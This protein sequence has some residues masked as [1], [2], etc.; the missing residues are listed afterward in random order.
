MHRSKGAVSADAADHIDPTDKTGYN[1]GRLAATVLLVRDGSDGLEVWAQERVRTMRNFPGMTVF[2]GGGVD[3]RDFPPRSWDS[4]ELWTGR[5]VV[6]FARRLGLTKYKSHALV[7]AA[8]REVFEETGILLV[9]D[10]SGEILPDARPY[11]DARHKLESHQLAL[12]D[13]LQDNKLKVNAD[14]LEPW[15]RFA[16]T[17]ESGNRFDTFSFVAAVPEGQEPDG[18][19]GEAHDA[20]WFSPTLLMEGWR[21]GLVRFAVATWAQILD[22]SKF[23][24]V[25]EVFE[26]AKQQ[27]MAPVVGDP[28]HIPRYQD[29]FTHTPT[30]RIGKLGGLH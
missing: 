21:V 7:F 17:S 12:T 22:L 5:S 2:P 15:G 20:N 25:E 13:V 9:N 11:A 28:T 3:S 8:V 24:T 16:G 6:S 4:G 27:D 18:E 19:T 30:D 26:A 29:F 14:L 23:H 1:G 10:E